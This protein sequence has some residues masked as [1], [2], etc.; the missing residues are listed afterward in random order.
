MWS[1][2]FGAE[3]SKTAFTRARANSPHVDNPVER[4]NTYY[5]QWANS[6]VCAANWHRHGEIAET[7]LT[8]SGERGADDRHRR[9][10]HRYPGSNVPGRASLAEART[11]LEEALRIY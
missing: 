4:F 9:V 2:G 10:A 1:K 11:H 3:E 6:F 5:G 7:L 8:R